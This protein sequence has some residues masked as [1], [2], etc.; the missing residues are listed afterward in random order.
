MEPQKASFGDVCGILRN[1]RTLVHDL[2]ERRPAATAEEAARH[3]ADD[4]TY[5]KAMRSVEALRALTHFL[6]PASGPNNPNAPP[7]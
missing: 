5:A 4:E 2:P 1:V 6:T 3:V 7:T